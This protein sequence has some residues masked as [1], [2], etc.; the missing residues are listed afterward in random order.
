MKKC[1]QFCG[2]ALMAMGIFLFHS[3]NKDETGEAVVK[4]SS[5]DY[6]ALFS[7]FDL[8]SEDILISSDE[9]TQKSAESGRCFT[10]TVLENEDGAFWPRSWTVD[11]GE[12]GCETWS[13]NVRKGKIHVT[14]SDWWRNEGALREISFENFY[15]NDHKLEGVKTILNNGEN[16][17]GHLTFTK[18]VTGGKLTYADD[19]V[20]SWNCEKI[21][22]M[23]EG[24][25]TLVFADD[26]WSVT[27][28][29]SGINIDGQAYTFT[30]T[31][32]LIYKNGCFRPVS[33]IVE[34]S[35]SGNL[36]VFDYGD[37]ECDNLVTVTA[38]GISETIEL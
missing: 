10:I 19:S 28:S 5:A 4:T 34:L 21:S 23:V 24:Q 2:V 16:E 25:E 37:G 30:I 29:G 8:D 12:A 26:V 38:G 36:Q 13:G 27:G 6:L 35:V 7:A 31:S 11:Y 3:C 20:M 32:P 15:V 33:G 14:L 17:S 9:N 18:K 1:I 22:E